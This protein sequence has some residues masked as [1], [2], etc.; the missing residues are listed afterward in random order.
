MTKPW[1]S[2]ASKGA[3]PRVPQASKQRGLEPAAML[4]GA[5][6]IEIGGPFQVFALFQHEGVRGA[7]VEPHIE[8]VA[9][10]LPLGRVIDKAVQEAR[11][12]R[13]PRTRR[14]RPRP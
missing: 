2:T 5:F 10:L 9:H 1:V 8:N 12:Q 13:R 11:R 14:P 3:R 4:V 7:G 6:E